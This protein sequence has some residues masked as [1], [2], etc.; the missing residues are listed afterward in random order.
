MSEITK[1]IY[2]KGLEQGFNYF[3]SKV[4]QGYK[5]SLFLSLVNKIQGPPK[6]VDERIDAREFTFDSG[7]NDTVDEIRNT[8]GANSVVNN[9]NDFGNL[10]NIDQEMDV[11]GSPEVPVAT[12]VNVKI[13]LNKAHQFKNS[14]QEIN[15]TFN[16]ISEAAGSSV[17]RI[18]SILNAVVYEMMKNTSNNFYVD[19]GTQTG[20]MTGIQGQFTNNAPKGLG[21]I[22]SCYKKLRDFL[23]S[24]VTYMNATTSSWLNNTLG[25]EVFTNQ[26]TQFDN[27]YIDSYVKNYINFGN[28][29]RPI[30]ILPREVAVI[31]RDRVR[32]SFVGLEFTNPSL[33]EDI[34]Y[35]VDNQGMIKSEKITLEN[36]QQQ[37]AYPIYVLTGSPCSYQARRYLVKT[38]MLYYNDA[39]FNK[40]WVN[41]NEYVNDISKVLSS[42]YNVKLSKLVGHCCYQPITDLSDESHINITSKFFGGFVPSD[43]N[44]T[45][46]YVKA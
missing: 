37:D 11:D 10:K 20:D 13:E 41:R 32:S 43:K 18:Y 4:T 27:A 12:S 25:G 30:M 45:K 9:V 16:L 36:G 15:N 42:E 33:V 24:N 23:N 40:D 1:K 28:L 34:P 8:Y 14:S 46:L 7:G 31:L 21:G 17:F 26:S 19:I 22:E 44:I 6:G 39:L 2:D 3:F 5:E 38:A 35:I 29:A